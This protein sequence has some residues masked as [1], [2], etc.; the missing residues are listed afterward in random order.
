MDRRRIINIVKNENHK[1]KK[2][3]E[4]IQFVKDS[5]GIE[6]ATEAM[7][8]F[9]HEALELLSMFPDSI[10]KDSLAQLVQFTIDRSK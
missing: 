3:A 4:V 8:R 1:P 2:V 10:Y 6:Y 7:N 5:G 9:H